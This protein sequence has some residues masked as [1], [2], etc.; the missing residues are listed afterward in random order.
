M[1]LANDQP[2]WDRAA[3][4][5]AKHAARVA[6]YCDHAE[7]NEWLSQAWLMN[8]SSGL[9]ELAYAT[10]DR[11]GVDI[12]AL[13]A[14]RLCAIETK[15][16]HHRALA[17]NGS[18][19]ARNAATWRELQLVQIDHDRAYHP[20]VFGLTKAE[21]LRHY[22]LHLA[23]IAGAFAEAADDE[24]APGD[25]LSRRLPDTL[26]FGVKIATAAS[27]KLPEKPLSAPPERDWAGAV[28]AISGD[29]RASR[30]QAGARSAP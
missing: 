1:T 20:D 23:K 9:C 8:A 14:D 22:A 2:H 11:A 30:A 27:F 15:S 3:R 13:Y 29:M 26:L 18:A 10:A 28:D 17:F 12:F 4:E 6:N 21:Q 25:M 19:A 16:V 7:H 5:A 24:I